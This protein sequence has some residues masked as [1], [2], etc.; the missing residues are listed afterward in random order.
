[1]TF[2]FINNLG[3]SNGDDA[4]LINKKRFVVY[5][6]ILMSLGGIL[7]GSICMYLQIPE[8]SLIPYGYVVLSFLNISL[9]AWKKWFRFTQGFQTGISLLLPFLFQWHL[10]GF[11]AS[12][13]VM[14]WALL[15]LAASLSYSRTR[16]SLFWLCTYVILVIITG[17]LDE[18]FREWYPNNYPQNLSVKLITLNISIVSVLI[19]TLVI[20]YVRENIRTNQVIKDTQQMLIQSEKLAALGQLSAGI[21]HE[22]NT[23]LGAIKS[24]VQDTELSYKECLETLLNIHTILK[25]EDILL[26][27]SMVQHYENKGVYLSTREERILKLKLAKQLEEYRVENAV[28]IAQKLVQIDIYELNQTLRHFIGD[29]FELVVHSLHTI[30]MSQKN[31]VTVLTAVEKASRVVQA[32]KMYLHVNEHNLPEKY[33]LRESIHTVLTIYHNQLKQGIQVGVDIPE[34]IELTGFAEEMN[35]V[36]TNLIVN[37]CQAMNFQGTLTIVAKEI[38]EYVHVDISDTGCGIPDDVGQRIFEPFFSTK[39]IGEGTGIG[40]DI[41]KRIIEKHFGTIN[42]SSKLFE[43]TTFHIRLKK[44][45]SKEMNSI[46]SNT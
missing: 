21:A 1:V 19:F 32:L 7:W 46:T 2:T 14:V 18:T 9:F 24:I 31:N 22:I 15:S 36:W 37:A 5:E 28:Y 33:N 3:I 11:Y 29:N 16:T 35:Q 17:L 8:K 34:K 45:L 30:L 4:I 23:P 40:L 6:A 10:G 44:D 25:Q 43:G 42:Y 39:K 41:V 38:D 26:F 13:G 20:F 27:H 12:G